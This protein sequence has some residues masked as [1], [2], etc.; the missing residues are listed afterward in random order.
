VNCP[1]NPLKFRYQTGR[2]EHVKSV[3]YINIRFKWFKYDLELVKL[4][5]Y[6][7][8]YIRAQYPIMFFLT[9]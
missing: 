5:I 7:Y 4:Y 1:A 6:I 2:K 3:K 9:P 8:T